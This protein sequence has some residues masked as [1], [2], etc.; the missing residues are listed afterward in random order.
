MWYLY[1]LYGQTMLN[2][3]QVFAH[4]WWLTASSFISSIL[5]TRRCQ[6][7]RT[8]SHLCSL[9]IFINSIYITYAEQAMRLRHEFH[10]IRFGCWAQTAAFIYFP[11]HLLQSQYLRRG[12][13]ASVLYSGAVCTTRVRGYA[14]VLVLVLGLHTNTINCILNVRYVKFIWQGVVIAQKFMQ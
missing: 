13:S 7:N 2:R 12:H 14:L 6:H 4:G 10:S 1:A 5:S 11:P 8:E 9:G 3:V